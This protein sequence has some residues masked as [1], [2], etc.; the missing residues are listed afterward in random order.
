MFRPRC[1]TKMHH[2]PGLSAT[3]L[4]SLGKTKWLHKLGMRLTF[5][6]FEGEN[7][8]V[9]NWVRRNSCDETIEVIA[10]HNTVWFQFNEIHKHRFR[11]Q[12]VGTNQ[13]GAMTLGPTSLL[14]KKRD[15]PLS[16]NHLSD[17][18]YFKKINKNTK[19]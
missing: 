19:S 14:I 7:R 11:I 1:S 18:H 3:S 6:S 16:Q 8:K 2:V 13:R 12:R 9:S 17:Q 4:Q 10:Y 5:C 15:L